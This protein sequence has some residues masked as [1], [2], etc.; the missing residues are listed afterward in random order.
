VPL[1]GTLR[2]R[3]KRWW[4]NVKL[5]GEERAKARPLKPQGAE[6]ATDD[7]AIAREVAVGMW[8]QALTETVEKRVRA[9]TSQTVARLKAQFLEKVRD[10]TQVVETTKARLE[11]ETQARA[12]AEARIQ[13]SAS[14]AVET[15]V[16]ECCGAAEIPTASVKRIDSGQLL[17]RSCVAALQAEIERIESEMHPQ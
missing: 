13:T 17:C 11:A 3:D 4:W 1:P 12:E 6:Q 14:S 7:L 2:Q 8:E 5:P 9:E 16:C 15:T 10:Y